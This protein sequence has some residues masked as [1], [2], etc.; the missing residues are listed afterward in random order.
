MSIINTGQA[1]GV[2][3]RMKL[4]KYLLVFNLAV[5]TCFDSCSFIV[6][7]KYFTAYATDRVESALKRLQLSGIFHG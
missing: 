2:R 6:A 7:G 4:S 3:R 5:F 1:V